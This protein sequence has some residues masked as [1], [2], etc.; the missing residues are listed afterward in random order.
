MAF[1]HRME[2]MDFWSKPISLDALIFQY[3]ESFGFISISFSRGET[4]KIHHTQ[5]T[6]EIRIAFFMTDFHFLNTAKIRL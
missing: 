1:H 6:Y 3:I 2:S 4:C 5:V